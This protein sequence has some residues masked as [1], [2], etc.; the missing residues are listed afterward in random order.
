MKFITTQQIEAL[1]IS[2]SQC[3]EWV[4]EGFMLKDRCNLPPKSAIHFPDSLDFI[5]TMPC[6]L[7]REF[8]RFGCKVAM[9]SGRWHPSVKSFLA[10]F[11]NAEG[12]LLAMFDCNWIT[13]MRTGA[14]AALA[15]MTLRNSRASVYSFMGLGATGN[16]SLQCFLAA[17]KDETKTVRL[18]KYKDHAERVIEE[19][20]DCPNVKFE[21]SE[22]VDQLVTDADVVVSCIT[23]APDLLVKN[24]D[25]LKPG[26]LLV[27]VHSR[28]FENCDTIFDKII[29]DDR[30]QISRF[31]YFNQ[32]RSFAELANVLKGTAPGR[33]ND[34]ERIIAYNFGI[35]VHDVIFGTKIEKMIL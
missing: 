6:L 22:S 7:P 21:V 29:G 31:R 12:E 17:T 23:Q 33:E 9:R 8:S 26:V 15:I 4:T 14:V 27:P 28:G 1:G 24:T 32:F 5:H 25:L 18:L 13:N 10:L 3:I 35:S 20:K 2:P 30:D 34:S 16:A 11:D 19:F